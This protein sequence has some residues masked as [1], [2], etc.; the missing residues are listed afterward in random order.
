MTETDIPALRRQLKIKA[1]ATARLKK[2]H[3]MYQKEAVDLKLKKDKLVADAGD[4]WDIKNTTRM[5]EESEKMIT[6]T[7]ERLGRAH[8][9]LRDVVVSAKKE[10]TLT[11][12]AEYL[13]A[14]GILEDAA[15]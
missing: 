6:D 4:E 11:G 2:E 9:E 1:G 12:D 10:P 8:G 5:L 13:K 7:A 3:D 15:L 14:E